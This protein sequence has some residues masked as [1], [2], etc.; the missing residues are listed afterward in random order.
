MYA[1]GSETAWSTATTTIPFAVASLITGLSAS[2]SDGLI[3]ITLAPEEMRLRMSAIWPVA[4]VV[5]LATITLETTPDALAWALIEQIIS[6]RQPLPV[7]VLDTPTTYL[8]AVP[9]PLDVPPH[10]TR[11]NAASIN[12]ATK[13]PAVR[14]RSRCVTDDHLLIEYGPNGP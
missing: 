8:V 1:E 2:R 3:T 6:S 13:R 4:S 7:S 14:G 11:A 12:A 5:R 9:P 10:A